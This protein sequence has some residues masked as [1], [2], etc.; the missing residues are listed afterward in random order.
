MNIGQ[1][2]EHLRPDF[3][4][5]TIP[6]I[7]FLEDKG[8]IKPE[9]TP[10]G[11]RKF[12]DADVHRLRFVLT[13]QRDHYLPLKVIGE[14][15]DAIDRGLEPPPIESVVPTVPTVAL[16]VDGT[17]S[18]ESFRRRSDLR[19]SRKELV[20]VAEI[21]EDMLSQL[22]QFGLVSP[23]PGTQQYDSDALLI[24]RTAA[25]LSVFGFE[26]RHLRAFKAAADREVGLVEQVVAPMARGRDT[27]ARARADD[28]IAEIAALSVRLHATLV[29]AGLRRH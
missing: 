29:K 26:P 3:P 13:M 12:S 27:A 11:Y 1:V 9:R 18:A 24:A 10:A 14:H 19:L 8:L 21:S 4:G 16:S 22:E 7:R 25:E 28:A 23:R 20:K 2:L 15:L 6:K 17:P 5:V